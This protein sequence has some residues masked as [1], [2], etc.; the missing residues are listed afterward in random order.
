MGT[1]GRFSQIEFTVDEGVASVVLNRPEMRNAF[2][3]E[4]IADLTHAFSEIGTSPEIRVAVLTGSGSA[5][6]AGADLQ[7][8]RRMADYS[9]EENIEDSRRMAE[10][11]R[12]IHRCPKPVIGRINGPAIGG[13]IGLVAVCDIVLS[14]ESAFFAF[15]EVKLGLL[16]AV[17][18]PYVIRRIGPARAKALFITGERFSAEEAHRF[19]LV[20]RVVPDDLL[21]QEV[22]HFIHLIRRGGPEAIT[23]AKDLVER[24]ISGDDD[25]FTVRLISELRASQE[26]QEGVR[27]FLEKREPKWRW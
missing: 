20:D 14:A 19:G 18:S 10:M 3:D 8:M 6:S 1:N 26:G 21:D 7:W 2:N 16:P 4:V 15:S 22:Q 24:V 5:F 12:T 27:A 17:I 25:D 9:M 13:G 23:R 11:F